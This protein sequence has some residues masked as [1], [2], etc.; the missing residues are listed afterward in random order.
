MC[1]VFI[2]LNE[3]NR[4]DES[5]LATFSSIHSLL[6]C[7]KEVL[8]PTKRVPLL[9]RLICVVDSFA[10]KVVALYSR[11]DVIVSKERRPLH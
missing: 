4:A 7:N 6:C 11:F 2:I 8:S 5:V 10:G 9:R 1:L 3:N